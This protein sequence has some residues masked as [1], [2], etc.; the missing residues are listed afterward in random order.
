[1]GSSA[2]PNQLQ[3]GL[4]RAADQAG[5][6]VHVN[7]VGSMFTLF[8]RP[9][10]PGAEPAQPDQSAGA[11]VTDFLSAKQSDPE[12]FSRFFWDMLKRGIYLPPSQ[13][14]AAFLSTAHTPDDIE[15][16]VTAAAEVFAQWSP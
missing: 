3:G 1:M 14:E 16:T 6:S 7:Q 9:G 2:W 12:R 4:I 10:N 15:E 11:P 5:V 8:F 13:F